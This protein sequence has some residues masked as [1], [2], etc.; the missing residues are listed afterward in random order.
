MILNA[1]KLKKTYGN[2]TIFSDVSM[3]IDEGEFVSLFGVSGSGKS[4]IARIILGLEKADEGEI[5]SEKAMMVFQQP[6][7]SLDPKQRIGKGFDEIIKYHHF[8]NGNEESKQ[9][10]CEMLKKVGLNED[11]LS[12]YPH[13]ISGGEAER[14]CIARAL[15]FSPKLLIM[16]EATSMLDAETTKEIIRLVRKLIIESGGSILFIS[17]DNELVKK[18]SDRIYVLSEG[19]MVE[20]K[21]EKE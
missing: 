9:L 19:N 10:A 21:N 16:D 6:S 2:K 17:H 14:V 15:L 1:S 3:Q 13:Q 11:I 18:Y 5:K 8:A 4:T 12:H 20:F 7:L